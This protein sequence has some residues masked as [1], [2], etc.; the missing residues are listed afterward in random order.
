[1]Y[2]KKNSSRSKK[3]FIVYLIPLAILSTALSRF[4]KDSSSPEVLNS[5]INNYK[6]FSKNKYVLYEYLFWIKLDKKLGEMTPDSLPE[7]LDTYLAS[8]LQNDP[9][10]QNKKDI[11]DFYL[12]AAF[13]YPDCCSALFVYSDKNIIGDIIDRAKSLDGMRKLR[14]I[15]LVEN[16]RASH[17]FSWSKTSLQGVDEPDGVTI[18]YVFTLYEKWWAL[19]IPL[20]DK[21]KANPLEGTSYWWDSI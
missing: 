8:I 9:N 10:I 5:T 19:P 17:G 4:Y 18:Q 14:A 13:Y 2:L 12:E 7:S 3:V 1:M 16:M 21:L 6:F 20:I 11:I 15:M